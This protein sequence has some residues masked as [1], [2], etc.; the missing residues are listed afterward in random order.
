MILWL[1]VGWAGVGGEGG[2]GEP[3]RWVAEP[4][5]KMWVKAPAPPS[6]HF[7]A[8]GLPHWTSFSSYYV[9]F[10]YDQRF[11]L[12]HIRTGGGEGGESTF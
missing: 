8:S 12:S 2:G 11:L 6:P 9:S 3:N 5:A 7:C 10:I 4:E 1:W